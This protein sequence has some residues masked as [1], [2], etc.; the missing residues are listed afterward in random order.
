MENSTGRKSGKLL[1]EEPPLQVL[2]SLAVKIGLNEAIVLQQLHFWLK[3]YEVDKE[4]IKDGRTWIY[5]S[6]SQWQE[7]FPWWS[8]ETIKRILVNLRKMKLVDATDKFNSMKID[9]T[10]WY[11]INYEVCDALGDVEMAPH[12]AKGQIDPMEGSDCAIGEV[13]LTQAITIDYT[14]TTSK[15]TGDA[16]KGHAA[17]AATAQSAMPLR[18]TPSSSSQE[19]FGEKQKAAETEMADELL[20]QVGRDPGDAQN[21]RGP[22]M[23][24]AKRLIGAGRSAADV[25]RWR[26]ERWD[27]GI[28]FH[29]KR[30]NPTLAHIDEGVMASWGAWAE[31][32]AKGLSSGNELSE[33]DKRAIAEQRKARRAT[34]ASSTVLPGVQ[35]GGVGAV[36]RASVG[37]AA[38]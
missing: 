10:L 28:P 20:R 3:K 16:P 27:A 5:N 37:S 30:E 31:D 36:G 33:E 21:N 25:R 23:S 26:R 14:K 19:V 9:K 15:R 35:G 13:N 7:N 24:K 29:G 11:T 8:K 34:A 2:P 18:G 17:V 22:Y 32:S 38:R 4:H 6:T 12:P 1:I